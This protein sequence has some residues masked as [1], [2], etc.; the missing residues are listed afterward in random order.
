[1]RARTSAFFIAVRVPL[2]RQVPGSHRLAK[3]LQGGQISRYR[4]T[5]GELGGTIGALGVEEIEQGHGAAAGGGF[6][7]VAALLSDLEVGGLIELSYARALLDR[8]VGVSYIGQY[9]PAGALLLLLSLPDG[10]TRL[11]NIAL[12]PVKNR[13]RNAERPGSPADAV[14]VRVVGGD[15]GILLGIRLSERILAVGGCNAQ[16]RRAQVRP[17]L[18]GFRLQFLDSD[19]QRP[20]FEFA[21]NVV[22]GRHR[23]I[24]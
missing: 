7:D 17:V 14:S 15:S 12:V 10:N 4:L 8:L 21:N 1:M 2:S 24:T 13:E 5:V 3:L 20:V 6:A 23:F 9:L 18:K 16:H 22:I 11:R 19:H